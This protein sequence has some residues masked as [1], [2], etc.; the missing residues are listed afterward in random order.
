MPYK[1]AR[2]KRAWNRRAKGR[3][4]HR[5]LAAQRQARYRA[6]KRR[7]RGTLLHTFKTA[8]KLDAYWTEFLR[9]SA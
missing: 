4:I 7:E 5:Y 8:E 2:D 6:R 3:W 9:R 1:D